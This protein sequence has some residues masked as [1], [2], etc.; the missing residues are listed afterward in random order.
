MH[1]LRR[2]LQKT[3]FDIRRIA[4]L[5]DTGDYRRLFG[6]DAVRDRRFYNI[7]GGSAL[8]PCWTHIDLFPGGTPA[9]HIRHDLMR[10]VP[11]PLDDGIAEL[12]YCGHTLGHVTDEAALFTLRESHRILKPGG[13]LRI[14]VCNTRLSHDA[15]RRG[16]RDFFYWEHD[17]DATAHWKHTNLIMPLSNA[18]LGQ[19]FLEDFAATASTITVE[20]AGERIGDRELEKV[21]SEM[22]L[23]SAF[24][25]CTGRCPPELQSRFPYHRM[26]WFHEGKLTAM[27][28][29][30]GFGDASLSGYLQSQ[31]PVWRNG[32]FF[33]TLPRITLYAEAVR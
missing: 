30:A 11:L 32:T 15:W 4:N 9:G 6:D 18:S 12:V 19:V 1:P 29:T 3:G 27:M 26:N 28:R 31:V 2:L 10:M 14:T 7:G 33:D 20:G 13:T 16:D 5:D 24:D 22:P 17:H 25:H 23:E 21:F 8:H